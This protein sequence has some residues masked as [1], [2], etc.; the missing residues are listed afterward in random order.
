MLMSAADKKPHLQLCVMVCLFLAPGKQSITPLMNLKWLAVW[1]HIQCFSL[2][3]SMIWLEAAALQCL[4]ANSRCLYYSLW[5]NCGKSIDDL[6]WYIFLYLLCFNLTI[7]NIKSNH[8]DLK[9]IDKQII[10]ARF[11][12]SLCHA[13][14]ALHTH[15]PSS[16]DTVL[17]LREALS[18][19]TMEL[20]NSGSW[21]KTQEQEILQR[22]TKQNKTIKKPKKHTADKIWIIQVMFFPHLFYHFHLSADKSHFLSV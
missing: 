13:S 20:F 7:Y 10:K 1:C 14:A 3:L 16:L 22:K 6:T 5:D 2:F 8:T 19:N 18:G 9:T 17:W 21:K 11:F 15:N 12:F 4:Q